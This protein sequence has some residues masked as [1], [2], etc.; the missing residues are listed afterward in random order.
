ME[1]GL[2]SHLEAQIR[3]SSR[4]KKAYMNSKQPYNAQLWVAIASLSKQIFDL[5][6]KMNYLERAL[7]DGLG[8]KRSEGNGREMEKAR[9][10]RAVKENKPAKKMK[11]SKGVK[12]A[13]SRF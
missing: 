8:K 6:L 2:R 13:L 10:Q 1:K 12:K 9:V 5:N 11:K 4:H 7:R 3:E